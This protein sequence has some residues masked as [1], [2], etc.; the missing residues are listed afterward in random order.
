MKAAA[1]PSAEK[2]FSLIFSHSLN[3]LIS[4][5]AFFARK[6]FGAKVCFGTRILLGVF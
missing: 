4:I 6:K 5:S 3:V 2:A 1:K